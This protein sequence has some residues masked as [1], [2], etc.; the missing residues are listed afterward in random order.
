MEDLIGLFVKPVTGLIATLAALALA[1]LFL[2]R[3]EP[4]CLL[5]ARLQGFPGRWEQGTC[6][7]SVD[8]THWLPLEEGGVR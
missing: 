8:G 2:V 4:G 6:Q 1:Y 5:Q 7:I 3:T